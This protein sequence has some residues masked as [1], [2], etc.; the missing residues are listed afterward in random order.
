MKRDWDT[1]REI[2]LAVEAL[3]AGNTLTL[4]AFDANRAHEISYHVKLMNEAG[5]I[6]ASISQELSSRAKN[7]HIRALTWT[8]H[9]LI[10]SIREKNIWNQIKTKISEKGGVMTFEIIKSV[11]S[12][13]VKT[14]L[15]I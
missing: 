10:D 15:G 2:L 4:K 5:L 12:N 1:V 13:L 8:G 11:A 14:A 7:F 6:E 9:E 3:D